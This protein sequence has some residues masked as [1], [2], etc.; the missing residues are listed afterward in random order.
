MSWHRL[1]C[2][3][4][5]C[6]C[7]YGRE[8]SPQTRP[9]DNQTVTVVLR[10]ESCVSTTGWE[11]VGV[12]CV[13]ITTVA[14]RYAIWT[15]PPTALAFT[16]WGV[17]SNGL[18]IYPMVLGNF[19]IYRTDGNGIRFNLMRRGVWMS[20]RDGTLCTSAEGFIGYGSTIAPPYYGGPCAGSCY[21]NPIGTSTADWADFVSIWIDGHRYVQNFRYVHG[22]PYL[23]TWPTDSSQYIGWYGYYGMDSVRASGSLHQTECELALLNPTRIEDLSPPWVWF[24]G[25]GGPIPS[26]PSLRQ[27]TDDIVSGSLWRT[28][29][30]PYPLPGVPTWDAFCPGITVQTARGA[31]VRCTF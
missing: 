16:Y 3:F 6:L 2:L 1:C 5:T 27:A 8:A 14:D 10:G 18:L 11:G 19:R 22:A 30:V 7:L 24:A 13:P 28:L 20:R 12:S 23:D 21:R 25:Y 26:N 29:Q 31:P 17:S 9:W 4:I 15:I